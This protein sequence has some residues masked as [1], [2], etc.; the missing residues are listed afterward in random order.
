MCLIRLQAGNSFVSL[1]Y[2][3]RMKLRTDRGLS[4]LQGCRFWTV[5]LLLCPLHLFAQKLPLEL[6]VGHEKATVDLTYFRYVKTK[7]DRNS[8]WLFFNRDRISVAYEQTG[9]QYQ[10]K[11]AMTFAMSYNPQ[12][13]K[14]VAPVAVVTATNQGVFPKLGMQYYT[15]RKDFVFFIWTIVEAMEDPDM[16]VFILTRYTPALGNRLKLYLQGESGNKFPLYDEAAWSL[17]QRARVG[18]VTGRVQWGLAAD[19]EQTGY[20]VFN[21]SNNVGVFLRYEF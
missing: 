10:P 9:G 4:L 3:A 16:E 17:F 8:R 20:Q 18:L 6:F 5:L 19:F 15:V 2:G 11:F 7:E 13:W 1:Q 12:N 14:G 21:R